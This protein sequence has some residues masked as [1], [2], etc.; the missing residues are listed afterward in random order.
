MKQLHPSCCLLYFLLLPMASLATVYYSQ[1]GSD[2]CQPGNWNS[3]RAGGG[4]SPAV[5][6]A[7]DVFVVQNGHQLT[8]GS[9]WSISGSGARLWIE[10]GG[11]L[12]ATDSVILSAATTFQIDNGGTYIHDNPFAFGST[13]F[14]GVEAFALNS[15]VELRNSNSTGPSGISFGNLIIN[16]QHNTSN[17]NL[18]GAIS[19][20]AGNLTVLSTNGF[21]LRLSTNTIYTL[22][23]A[24]NLV[25][26]GGTVN[27][28]SGTTADRQ[29]NLSIGG[30]FTQA[31]GTFT[32]TN[33]SP[34]SQLN[35]AF[36]GASS[37]FSRT[38]GTLNASNINWTVGNNASLSLNSD[39]SVAASRTFTM[40][41]GSSMNIAA[42]V[43][44]SVAGTA[45]FNH[46]HVT[47]R[48]SIDGTA[49]IPG[50]TGALLN[51]DYVTTERFIGGPS[52]KRAWR[53]IAPTVTGT[54]IN[55][56][57]QEGTTSGNPNPGYG[58][59]ITGGT[60]INGFDGTGAA[61]IKTYD[62]SNWVSNQL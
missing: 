23:I 7:G 3:L 28:S 55:A 22:T 21:E 49:T 50:I 25:I 17:V 51:A 56:A 42:G 18:N 11:T 12:I 47:L 60:A 1:A 52:P 13:I 43:S 10:N 38:G 20:I 36:T 29:F 59:Q 46:Q 24:G 41:T 6:T 26:S 58:T 5:F 40:N 19:T 62:G 2:P 35:L 4:S 32:H 27:G 8:T 31:G 30:N 53:L 54:S 45:D 14:K 34:G 61:S 39:F 33:T 57:W 9:T 37:T 48:S 16:L 44:F 15:T